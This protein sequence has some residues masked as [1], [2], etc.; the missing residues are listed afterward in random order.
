MPQKAV[1]PVRDHI[2]GTLSQFT[3]SR[4]LKFLLVMQDNIDCVAAAGN[5][6]LRGL[7][8]APLTGSLV[9]AVGIT[10]DLST[11]CPSRQLAGRKHTKRRELR[12]YQDIVG[13]NRQL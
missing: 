12:T 1:G 11:P 6:F 5:Q 4:N 8:G 2:C 10:S 13:T 7:H 9:L 3:P